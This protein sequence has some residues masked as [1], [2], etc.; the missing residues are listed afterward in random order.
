M[1]RDANSHCQ[2]ILLLIYL[3]PFCQSA[4]NSP[5]EIVSPR[6]RRA[7]MYHH[8]HTTINVAYKL[9][10][11]GPPLLM[12]CFG[13]HYAVGAGAMSHF[14]K[15][16]PRGFAPNGGD[17]DQ[18]FLGR[19]QEKEKKSERHTESKRRGRGGRGEGKK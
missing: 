1:R 2:H 13:I 10:A 15:I 7:H 4:H 16:A 3:W 6:C 8:I 18:S 5:L 19:K 17:Q 9:L 14:H 12:L 11:A